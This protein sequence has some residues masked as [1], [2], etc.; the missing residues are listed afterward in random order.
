M[1]K[2]KSQKEKNQFD[3]KLESLRKKKQYVE[4]MLRL[5]KTKMHTDA[6]ISIKDDFDDLRKDIK[7]IMDD[8]GA[9]GSNQGCQNFEIKDLKGKLAKMEEENIDLKNKL[10]NLTNKLSMDQSM[11]E[12]LKLV[13]DLL[14]KNNSSEA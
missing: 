6:E 9:A 12:E 1:R 8:K 4:L 2:I 3:D 11:M 13:K 14:L 7:N 5:V 10:E